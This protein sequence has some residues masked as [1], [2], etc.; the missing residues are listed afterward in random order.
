MLSLRLL[1]CPASLNHFSRVIKRVQCGGIARTEP[2]K[3]CTICLCWCKKIGLA[4]PTQA[5]GWNIF[6]L[7]KA[8]ADKFEGN[9]H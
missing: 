4:N 9:P 1:S 2:Q 5:V 7:K 8:L 3:I 6:V